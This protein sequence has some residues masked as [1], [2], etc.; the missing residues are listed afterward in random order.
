M[1]AELLLTNVLWSCQNG[2]CYEGKKNVRQK[3]HPILTPSVHTPGT[4]LL[5]NCELQLFCCVS[6]LPVF[7]VFGVRVSVTFHLTCVHVILI[8]FRLL[9]DHLLGYSYSFG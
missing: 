8:R 3:K 9:S 1:S 6:L 4:Y 7:G 5:C 2:L